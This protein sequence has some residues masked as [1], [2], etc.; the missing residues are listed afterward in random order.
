MK[1]GNL[2][3]NKGDY[4]KTKIGKMTAPTKKLIAAGIVE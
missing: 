4:A 3:P 1:G 2:S